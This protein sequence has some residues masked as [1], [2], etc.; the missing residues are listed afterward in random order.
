MQWPIPAQADQAAQVHYDGFKSFTILVAPC[1][2]VRI[3]VQSEIQEILLAE[4]GIVGFG[5]R[6]KVQGIPNSSKNCTLPLTKK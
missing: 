1:K 3:L 2:G 4:R 5:V 6:N